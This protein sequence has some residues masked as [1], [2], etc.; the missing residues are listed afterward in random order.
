[1][2]PLEGWEK[3]KPEGF[4]CLKSFFGVVSKLGNG[5]WYILFVNMYHCSS[6]GPFCWIN[7]PVSMI[8][9]VIWAAF[10]SCFHSISVKHHST[11]RDLKVTTRVPVNRIFEFSLLESERKFHWWNQFFC[12]F[13]KPLPDA[14][15]NSHCHVFIFFRKEWDYLHLIFEYGNPNR[16]SHS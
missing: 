3:T 2:W 15:R 13:L 4:K 16:V 14:T 8:N 1:M 12:A 11:S 7:E 10:L 9:F 5:V 6:I